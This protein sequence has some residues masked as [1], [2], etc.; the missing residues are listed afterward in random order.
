MLARLDPHLLRFD[1]KELHVLVFP[2]VCVEQNDLDFRKHLPQ[3]KAG[4]F[5]GL[6]PVDL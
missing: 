5:G 2:E 6:R 3:R 4:L 1:R